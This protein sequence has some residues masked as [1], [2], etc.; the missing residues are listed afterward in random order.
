M[1]KIE[2]LC[3]NILLQNVIITRLKGDYSERIIYR[4]DHSEGSLIGVEG[5]NIAENIAFFEFRRTFE[6]QGIAVPAIIAMSEDKSSY[7]LED[8]GDITVKKYCDD[9]NFNNDTGSIRTIYLKIIEELPRIQ[10]LLYD[11]IDYS[12]CYQREI[13]DK[14]NMIT[15]I[16]R[17]EEYFLRKFYKRY[18]VNTFENFKNKIISIVL[19]QPAE[20]FMYRDFQSRNMMLKDNNLFF[21]DFQSGRKG[22]L[23]YDLASFIYSSGTIRYESMEQELIDH[24]LRSLKN[25]ISI[26][27]N[28]FRTSLPAFGV[29]RLMQA[30]GNYAYYFYV[31]GDQSINAKINTN[32]TKIMELSSALGINS[33][34]C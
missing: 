4:I 17:F 19:D 21:I 16:A 6:E 2:K 8:L 25:Y 9:R 31:R 23:Q 30:L 7:I 14:E 1:I 24:Y 34:I 5:N 18:E 29:I 13:F 15:D 33:G 20:F 12:Y 26:D 28:G 3:E 27:E 32:I 11:K 10:N 22:P